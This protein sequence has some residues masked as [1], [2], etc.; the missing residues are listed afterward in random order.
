MPNGCLPWQLQQLFKIKLVNKDGAFV[1]YWLCLALN[2]IPE[3]SGNFDP[4]SKFVQVTKALVPLSLQGFSLGNTVGCAHVIPEIATSRTTADGR[5]E[6]P[7]VNS[8]IYL[9]TWND[10]YN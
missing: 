7:I 4:V 1:E 9:V 5:N 2:T 10:E 8:H 3:N 6:P